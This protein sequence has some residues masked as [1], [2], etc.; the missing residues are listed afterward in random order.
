MINYKHSI[1]HAIYILV[2]IKVYA[3]KSASQPTPQLLVNNI[4]TD[5]QILTYVSFAAGYCNQKSVDVCQI[6]KK[7]NQTDQI[8][9]TFSYAINENSTNVLNSF[10]SLNNFHIDTFIHNFVFDQLK[11]NHELNLSIK[12][13]EQLHNLRENLIQSYRSSFLE[14][15]KFWS[16]RGIL[17]ILEFYFSIKFK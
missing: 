6:A 8:D 14:R 9:K 5:E 2:L 12:C 15:T 16:Q 4:K 17:I 13:F 1:L 7:Q 10:T 3:S 11:T